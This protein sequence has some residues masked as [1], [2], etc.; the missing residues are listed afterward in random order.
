MMRNLINQGLSKSE[1]ASR[2][3]TRKTVSRNLLKDSIPKYVRK[4]L[5][6]NIL[7]NYK[8]YIDSRLEKY[9][10]S[11]KKLFDEIKLQG[12]EG[13]YQTVSNYVYS[14]E[15]RIQDKSSNKI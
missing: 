5:S 15:T 14:K 1:I 11:A 8:C 12:Y 9:N 6:T 13:C 4:Q 10:L 7:S 2:L 3:V